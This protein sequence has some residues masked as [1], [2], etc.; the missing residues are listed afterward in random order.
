MAKVTRIHRGKSSF[1]RHYLA[2]WLSARDMSPMDLHRLLNEPES[3]E[4][5]IDK[6]QVYRWV[7]EG[8]LPHAPTM[9]RIADA[10]KLDSPEDL[11]R[12]PNEDWIAKFLRD[13]SEEE[14]D[15][16]RRSL[17]VTFPKTGTTGQ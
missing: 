17:E 16:I 1:R 6:K 14:L 4:T 3:A 7:D 5:F 15:R 2:E 8:K 12:H 11:H 9:A 10:L 13:R